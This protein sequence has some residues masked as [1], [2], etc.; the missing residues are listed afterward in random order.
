[1]TMG[2]RAITMAS[3]EKVAKTPKVRI[4]EPKQKRSMETRKKILDAAAEL[5]AEQGFDAATS[6]LI[7]QKAGVSIGSFYAHFEDKWE[8][9]LQIM[10]RY[11][12]EMY[13]DTV[14]L[15]DEALS[16]ERELGQVFDWV[17]PVLYKA[18]AAEGKLNQ[19]ITKFA[20]VDERAQKIRFAWQRKEDQE[21][22]R[23]LEAIKGK[24]GLEDPEASALVIHLMFN[25]VFD[26]LFRYRNG[27][28]EKKVL[29]AFTDILKRIAGAPAASP[30]PSRKA[31]A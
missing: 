9:F 31:K 4:R 28:D 29:A 1:M 19:E 27:F 18:H 16:E 17:V 7:A 21:V 3:M 24:L 2:R 11:S 10:E 30:K 13:R 8:V 26:F 25:S 5:F 23:L 15:V 20:M 12:E 22:L 14:S 6:T